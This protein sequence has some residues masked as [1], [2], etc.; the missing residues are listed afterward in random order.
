MLPKHFRIINYFVALDKLLIF[1]AMKR[2]ALLMILMLSASSLLAQEKKKDIY[3]LT[4]DNLIEATLHHDNGVVAQ[5][6]FY[7]KDGKLHGEWTS[8]DTEGNKTAIATYNQGVKTGK[9]FFFIE[10]DIKE[11]TFMESRIAKVT[12]WKAS[13]TRVV[14]N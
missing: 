12:T 3:V 4:V 9:W 14:A 11:V 8:Y 2:Y 7:T 13:D 5:K 6:G 10:D 1:T